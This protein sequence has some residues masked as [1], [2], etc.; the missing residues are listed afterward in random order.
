MIFERYANFKY[1]SYKNGMSV[2]ELSEKY[3]LTQKSIQRIIWNMQI[4]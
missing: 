2:L 4:L 1:S 3:F